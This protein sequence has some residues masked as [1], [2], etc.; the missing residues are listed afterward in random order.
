MDDMKRPPKGDT[1]HAG[2]RVSE[3]VVRIAD[4]ADI[5]NGLER[6]RRHYGVREAAYQLAQHSNLPI[7]SPFV[8]TTYKAEWVLRYVLNRY[9]E[10]DPVV[11]RGFRVD[12]PFFWDELEYKSERE[13]EFLADARANGVPECG[14]CIPIHDKRG[15][16][17]LLTLAGDGPPQAWRQRID[18]VAVDLAAIAAILHRKALAALNIVDQR[19]ILSRREVE[20]LSWTA[21]GKDAASIS[22]IVGLSEHTV[23]DYL[24][25]AR[26]KLGCATI[27]QAVYEAALLRI[28]KV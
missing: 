23:R 6:I 1:G 17:A 11:V 25:S 12:E 8:R 27:A 28:L 21:K 13:V 18:P 3:I 10:I 14:Y 2:E 16:R 15:L 22:D 5:Q 26:L 19:P 20:C 9:L 24:K 7:D 4:E